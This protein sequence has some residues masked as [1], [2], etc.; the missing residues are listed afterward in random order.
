[1]KNTTLL[2]LKMQLRNF[3]HNL[4]QFLSVIAI[5]AIAITLFLGLQSNAMVFENQVNCVFNQGNS[6]D[7]YIT[8][9]GYDKSDEEFLNSILVD[10]D[11]M[12]GRI[13]IPGKIG[14]DNVYLSVIN[15]LPKIS[16]P[17]NITYDNSKI[18]NEDDK[19]SEENNVVYKVYQQDEDETKDDT[20]IHHKA[21]EYKLDSYGNKIEDE[22]KSKYSNFVMLDKTFKKVSDD[23]NPLHDV[24]DYGDGA[25]FS[26]AFAQLGIDLT[27][28]TDTLNNLLKQLAPNAQ[29]YNPPKE[30]VI[31]MNVNSFMNHPEN[32]TKGSFNTSIVLISMHS[33]KNAAKLFI[34]NMVDEIK[35]PL[36]EA[37]DSIK[38]AVGDNDN[39]KNLTDELQNLLDG[40]INDSEIFN[41]L[42]AQLSNFKNQYLIKLN[43]PSHVNEYKRKVNEYFN[44]KEETNL[45]MSA[46]KEEMPFCMTLDAD[47]KQAKQ[48]VYIFPLVFFLVAILVVLT[49]LSQ[50]VVKDRQVIGTM[51][52]I[53]LK[54]IQI[55]L[56]YMLLSSLLV[57]LG[58]I[59]GAIIGPLLIPNILG[60]KYSII[61]TLPPK[62]YVFPTTLAI[63]TFISYL[64]ITCLVT[65]L[66][67]R[68]EVS[69]KPVES[70]RPAEKKFN[71]ARRETSEKTNVFSLSIK[72][73]FR[74]IKLNIVKSLMVVFGILGCTSL[75]LAGFGIDDTIQHGLENDFNKFFNFDLNVSLA[76]SMT[77]DEM[78]SNVLSKID[79][80]DKT[81]SEYY[82]QQAC[83]FVSESGLQSTKM[84][85]L[86]ST[87]P[88]SNPNRPKDIT[89]DGKTFHV[90]KC[91]VKRNGIAI[92][93][94]VANTI[95]CSLYDYITIQVNSKNYKMEVTS[96]FDAFYYNYGIVSFSQSVKSGLLKTDATDTTKDKSAYNGIFLDTIK[97][98]D[99]K[100]NN[101]TLLSTRDN[102]LKDEYKDFITSATTEED[103]NITIS[104]TLSGIS[105]MTNAVKVFA[106][107]LAIVVVYNLA[108]MNNEEKTRDIATLKVLGFKRNEI[109]MSL[110]FE[111]L[112][113]TIIGV[114][115]GSFTG[116]P[117]LVA[118]MKANI[119]ELVEYQYFL[120]PL[121][122]ILSFILT[123]VV[124]LLINTYFVFKT[125]KI[126]MVES[127]KSV[128]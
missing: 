7:L 114:I 126:K 42:F 37:L 123:F 87:D 56:N 115:F 54:K 72:M 35:K 48:F 32:I 92:S 5:G 77:K 122:Y 8:T 103:F 44:E 110:L 50:M 49:T 31:D 98:D 10:D 128:E 18:E 20:V 15:E 47:I 41:S 119:V 59:I 99:E 82:L 30:L 89:D 11:H 45:I 67:I 85:Y 66:V 93:K 24:Y 46:S 116:F 127:L 100:K 91:G 112:L 33:F 4:G 80:V 14:H 52:A 118:I 117:F 3:R 65:F 51:K 29:E 62:M 71:K 108:K 97:T 43:K 12:E 16:K 69:L 88:T 58:T 101:E 86:L 57:T 79:S 96:I 1:M 75:L 40:N 125:R 64:L 68:K 60:E 84:V 27:Q 106:I 94:K 34:K 2:L 81:N 102:L 76:Q 19:Y 78:E 21:G 13:Y 105:T 28:L 90:S 22:E 17:Y 61:Y 36:Q 26:I 104:S 55:Y 124:A 107:L 74:N 95:N 120:R 38:D 6:P 53:G 121:S 109:A 9:T 63:I 25:K 39:L 111:V 83:T 73:A 70:L 23:Q 113:L